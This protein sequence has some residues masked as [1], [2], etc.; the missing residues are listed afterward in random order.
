MRYLQILFVLLL[1]TCNKSYSQVY[2]KAIKGTIVKF[3]KWHKEGKEEKLGEYYFVPRYDGTGD[4]KRY[5]DRDSLELYYNNFRHSGLISE[6]YIEQLKEYF[7][8]YEK[9]LGDK[10]KDGEL[11][12]IEGLDQDIVLNTFEP[13][14]ILENIGTLKIT[15]ILVIYNKA[16]VGINFKRNVNMIFQL[17]KTDNKWLIDYIGGDNTNKNSAFSQ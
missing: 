1:F 2:D 12:K 15:K 13:E 10:P 9:F 6:L 4:R 11:I 16:L 17:T 3:L 5:F 8:Y 14:E 7:N